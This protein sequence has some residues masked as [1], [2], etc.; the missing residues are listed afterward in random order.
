MSFSKPTPRGGDD[1][2]DMALVGAWIAVLLAVAFVINVL[3][4]AGRAA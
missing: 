3:A 2:R 1:D 4:I